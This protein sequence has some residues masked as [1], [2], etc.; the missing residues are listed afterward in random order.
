MSQELDQKI[1][2]YIALLESTNE[3]LV[4]T[5]KK[6]VELLT[7]FKSS[8]PDP[9]KGGRWFQNDLNIFYLLQLIVKTYQNSFS[10]FYAKINRKMIGYFGSKVVLEPTSPF[11]GKWWFVFSSEPK[12]T[13]EWADIL[14]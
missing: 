4:K 9:H 14:D 10:I 8:V 6:C 11:T 3:E 12:L 13:F 1:F 7:E 2:N 5:L